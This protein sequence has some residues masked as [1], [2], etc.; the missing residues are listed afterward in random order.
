MSKL[1]KI[2]AILGMDVKLEQVK[3]V[4]GA[5]LGADAFEPGQAVFIIA[6]GEQVPLPVS[7]A[8]PY[9]LED[10]RVLEVQEEGI[11]FSVGN[12]QEVEPEKEQEMEVEQPAK[13][14]VES[15]TK[16]THFNEEKVLFS[17]EQM[18]NLKE[19]FASWYADLTAV[20]EVEEVEPVKEE[21]SKVEPIKHSPEKQSDK[22]E[23][24]LYA[25]K[26]KETTRD[27]IFNKLFNN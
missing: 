23:T 5:I 1:N 13:K 24:V 8:T 4:S 25:T 19:M 9:E 2:R 17:D 11:I 16:E 27:R 10:G 22:K 3:T 15:T 18:A 21:L 12:A 26:R 20:E 6:D 14:V 7:N